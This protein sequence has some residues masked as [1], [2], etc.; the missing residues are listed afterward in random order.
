M[1]YIH[2]PFDVDLRVPR[3]CRFD[4]HKVC[5]ELVRGR[6]LTE[7]ME[8][9]TK[10]RQVCDTCLGHSEWRYTDS[11]RIVLVVV[12]R[13]QGTAKARKA[14]RDKWWDRKHG[15]QKGP[16]A[17]GDRA[18]SS[19]STQLEGESGACER[20]PKEQQQ[21]VDGD[22][23]CSAQTDARIK[24]PRDSSDQRNEDQNEPQVTTL[25]RTRPHD[26]SGS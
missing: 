24:R 26:S 11:K 16:C 19:G 17:A 20:L 8:M 23:G 22:D 5:F 7:Y 15:S 3:F 4:G 13:V 9:I 6:A 25:K 1:P 21:S 18:I 14:K 12:S 10:I 2:E